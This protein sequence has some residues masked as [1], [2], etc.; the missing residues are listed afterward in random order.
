MD[1]H[2]QEH[3]FSKL[4]LFCAATGFIVGVSIGLVAIG[5]APVETL[6]L[7]VIGLAFTSWG[8]LLYRDH[9]QRKQRHEEPNSRH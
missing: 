1:R 3:W 8:Y 2:T 6:V 5:T 9:V 7:G 4:A